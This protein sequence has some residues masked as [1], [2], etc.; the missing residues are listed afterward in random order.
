MCAVGAY[1]TNYTECAFYDGLMNMAL[2]R[3]AT[4]GGVSLQQTT[5]NCSTHTHVHTGHDIRNDHTHKIAATNK[6][7][8][9]NK[10]ESL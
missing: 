2:G 7:L 10:L 5:S 8:C 6:F 1:L 3:H 4:A 9:K